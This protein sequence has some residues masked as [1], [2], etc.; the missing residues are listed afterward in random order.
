MLF[1]A[2]S[3]AVFALF[4]H[5]S[6]ITIKIGNVDLASFAASK[7][8]ALLVGFIAGIGQRVLSAQLIERTEKA[9]SPSKS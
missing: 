9:I 2:A 8:V 1:V 7:S 3:A 5:L 4:L 6:I